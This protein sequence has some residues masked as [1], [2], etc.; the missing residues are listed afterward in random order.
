MYPASTSTPKA[1]SVP[2][3]HAKE[4][5]IPNAPMTC[6]QDYVTKAEA[7]DET[8][9]IDDIEIIMVAIDNDLDKFEE[10]FMSTEEVE[11][12]CS[13]ETPMQQEEIL[14]EDIT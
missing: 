8:I 9:V 13:E 5:E 1:T 4:L 11:I 10:T 3:E 14:I 12:L 2:F 6:P 7:K